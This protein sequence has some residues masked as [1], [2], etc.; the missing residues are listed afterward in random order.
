MMTSCLSSECS[1]TKELAFLEAGDTIYLT[2]DKETYYG[3]KA[4][5]QFEDEKGNEFLFLQNRGDRGTPSILIYNL[6]D[7]SVTKKIPL[8]RE[9]PNGIPAIYG[10][11]A[12]DASHFLVT[13]DSPHF[14]IVNDKGEILFRSPGLYDRKKGFGT[15]CTTHVMSYYH[16]PAILRDSLLYFSQTH[17]GYPHRKDTWRTSNIF[18]VAD[19]RSGK[20]HPLPM[21]YPSIFDK[22][23][24]MRTLSYDRGFSYADTGKEVAV[25]FNKSD[26]IY[27]SSD[28]LHVRSYKAQSRYFPSLH[29]EPYY[30][31][32][33]LE[34]RLRRESLKPQY[35]HLL[36]DKYRKVFYRFALH[37]YEWPKTKSPM[38]GE[39]NGRKFSILIL[40][41]QYQLIG[42]TKFPA[43]QYAY[44]YYFIGKEGLYVSLNNPDNPLFSE[45]ELIFQC[46]RIK[47]NI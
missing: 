31:Q 45:D 17:I 16:Q 41:E 42:E 5:F 24:I 9:G 40:D 20:L 27:V 39:D 12:L 43:Y 33:D 26:S 38:S 30:A 44:H 36:Y 18:A 2:V 19:L 23:E 22:E 29:P 8:F 4:M 15:F 7:C 46:F 14:Y 1:S 25:S 37:P 6:S 34:A 28:F 32:T 47:K 21:S 3:S 13:T 35:H 11:T 10:G